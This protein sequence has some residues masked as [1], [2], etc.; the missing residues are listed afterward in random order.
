M[1]IQDLVHKERCVSNWYEAFYPQRMSFVGENK[2]LRGAGPFQRGQYHDNCERV[3]TNG[4]RA[5][6]GSPLRVW[7]KHICEPRVSHRLSERL[8]LGS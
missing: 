4:I 6:D 7:V 2:T 5:E 1:S 3:F 8:R